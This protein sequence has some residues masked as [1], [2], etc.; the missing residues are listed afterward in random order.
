[1]NYA[2]GAAQVTAGTGPDR[3]AVPRWAVLALLVVAAWFV[4]THVVHVFTEA[5]N[6]DEFALLARADRSA[7]L[8]EVV[9]DG[10][11]GLVS[12]LLIPFVIDC[13][14]SVR[15]VVHARALWTFVTLAYLGGVYWLVRRWFAR[16]GRSA[17]GR[18][19]GLLAVALLAFLPAFVTWSVQVRTDQA[20]LAAATWGGVALLSSGLPSAAIAG[21]LFGIAVLAT[22][23]AIYVIALCAALYATS[24]TARYFG[25]P[26][27]SS[28]SLR[29]DALRLVAVAVAAALVVYLYLQFVPQAARLA[30]GAGLGSGLEVMDWVRKRQGYRSYTVHAGRLVVHWLMFAILLAW[31]LRS[32]L[33]RDRLEGLVVATS[34][35]VLT[36]G[37]AVVRFHGS[38]FPYFLMTAGLFPAVGMALAAGGPLRLAGRLEWPVVVS[39]VALA[40]VQSAPEALEMT[41]DSQSTQRETM[42]LILESGLRERRGY[43]VE[44]ALF[45]ARDPDPIP[46]L[47]SQGIWQKFRNNPL[48]V[49]AFVQ[50]FRNRPIAYIVESYRMNQFPAEIRRFF[51]E[52]YVWHERGLLVSGV[53]ISG[54][55]EVEADIIVSGEYRWVPGPQDPDATL[56]VD[57]RDLQPFETAHLQVG[58]HKIAAGPGTEG[59]RLILADLPPPRHDAHEAFYNPRQA[60]QL[61]GR[62]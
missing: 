44:G 20:A 46:A 38:G 7:R 24:T 28:V 50:E 52:H 37:L 60:V 10:R 34:W 54:P 8:G 41:A 1:M 9:G 62:R 14:D 15:T 36:L 22:Q 3:T 12:V 21:L 61:G 31:T 45:C 33:R 23:K 25:P 49:A 30:S 51:G 53:E 29:D 11:P 57:S 35:L 48:A 27:N 47:F 43:N 18:V 4:V 17:D 39:L 6:W 59:G 5:V 58:P 32:A 19:Q 42:R 16:V 13:V 55:M 26:I 40:G 2:Q 56:E